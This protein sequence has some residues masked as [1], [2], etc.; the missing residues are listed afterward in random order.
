MD[1][2]KLPTRSTQLLKIAIRVPH[3]QICL[4]SVTCILAGIFSFTSEE[5]RELERHD[6]GLAQRLLRLVQARHV[7]E[8]QA[9]RLQHRVTNRQRSF[10]AFA[11]RLSLVNAAVWSKRH[12]IKAQQ[13]AKH[14]SVTAQPCKIG[15]E[16]AHKRVLTFATNPTRVQTSTVFQVHVHVYGFA[17]QN[18]IHIITSIT[19]QIVCIAFTFTSIVAFLVDCQLCFDALLM[20]RQQLN[21]LVQRCLDQRVHHFV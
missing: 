2:V 19:R 20:L 7:V 10:L 13:N 5:M 1:V 14:Q 6:D 16:E 11:T 9:L 18:E 8:A 17:L 15:C 12:R 21:Q 3:V 4:R